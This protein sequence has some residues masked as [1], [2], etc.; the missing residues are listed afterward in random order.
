[1]N[2]GK[3]GSHENTPKHLELYHRYERTGDAVGPK[4]EATE[5]APEQSNV[6]SPSLPLVLRKER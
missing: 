4:L 6:C 1:M 2:P 3:K 5:R